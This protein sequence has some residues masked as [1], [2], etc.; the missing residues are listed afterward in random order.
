MVFMLIATALLGALSIAMAYSWHSRV[1]GLDGLFQTFADKFG[2]DHIEISDE[3]LY[4]DCI[5]HKWVLEN[6]VYAE[7]TGVGEVLMNLLWDSTLLATVVLSLLMGPVM[8]I[9][10]LILY[11]SF[12]FLGFS[13]AVVILAV[14]VIMPPGNV[15]MSYRFLKWLHNQE[16]SELKTNDMAFAKVSQ[17]SIV[18]WARI[19]VIVAS[20][21]FMIA[22]WAEVIPVLVAQ[23][24]AGFF[25]V[26]YEVFYGPLATAVSPEFA[27]IVILYVTPL[28]VVVVFI[29]LLIAVRH[30]MTGLRRLIMTE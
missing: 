30:S 15:T 7:G 2:S 27:L 9:A 11:N 5:S 1:A 4:T 29:L 13:F 12:A 20:I 25:V 19:L 23:G 6:I 14:F 17:N 28:S 21:S 26:V 22:P 24:I 16:E 18:M 10:V 3:Q 8:V